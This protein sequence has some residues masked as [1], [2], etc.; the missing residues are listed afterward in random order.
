[1]KHNYI[2]QSV[3][4]DN[5]PKIENKGTKRITIKERRVKNKKRKQERKYN[6]IPKKYS[7]YIKSKWW[8]IR[9]NRYFQDY[10]KKCFICGS[11]KWVVLHH[12]EYKQSVYGN[13]PDEMLVQLCKDH[14]EEFHAFYGVKQKMYNEF[15]EFI[16]LKYSE[17][18]WN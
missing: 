3:N 16:D 5:L 9:R 12:L 7:V 13:E 10:G 1:M 15:D 4:K 8:K 18:L 14:H 17:N 2:F 6:R 11:F